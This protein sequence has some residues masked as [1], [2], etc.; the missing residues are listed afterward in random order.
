[1]ELLDRCLYLRSQINKIDEKLARIRSEVRYPKSQTLSDVPRGASSGESAIERYIVKEEE[2]TEK[3]NSL[4]MEL[5]SSWEEVVDALAE[6]DITRPDEV[7]LMKLR[8]YRGF[9]WKRCI[10]IMEE[11]ARWNENKVYRIHR[12]IVQL[13]QNKA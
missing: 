8:Y 1:M 9:K 7:A 2:Y 3:R 5:D 10:Q 12:K 6:C 11:R 4:V 13:L